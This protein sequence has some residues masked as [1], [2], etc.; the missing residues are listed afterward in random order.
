MI[1]DTPV[2]TPLVS[3]ARS[4][5]S[6]NTILH[7]QFPGGH[8]TLAGSNSPS[9]L[10]SRPIRILEG[11]EI[12][13]WAVSAGAEGSPLVLAI[14]RTTTFWN[15]KKIFASTPTIEGQSNIAALFEASDRRYYHV[16][17]YRCGKFQ[18]LEWGYVQWE[19]GKPETAVYVCRY[20][21]ASWDDSQRQEAIMEGKW[22][23]EA[24]FNGTAGFH[25]WEAYNPWVKLA[26]MAKAFLDAMKQKAM[27]NLEPL[28]AF[29]NTSLGKTW[30][31]QAEAVS[32]DP[33][34][35][36][37]ENYSLDA[38]PW[39]VLYLTCG[40][41]VQDDRLEYEIVGWRAEKRAE[42]EQSWGLENRL[43][44]G[45]P[46]RQ[47]VWDELDEALKR[48]YTTQD[49]RKLRIGATAID[50]GGHHT[51]AVYNFCNKRLG[52]HVYAIKG[53][54]GPR[55]MWPPRAGQSRKF[56][57]SKVWI[58]G[59]DSAK[60]AI[61][62]RLRMTEPGPG[63]CHF[64]VSYD[65][66]FFRQLTA[67]K[68]RTKFVKGF[69]RREWFKAEGV[70]NEA[71]DR[72]VYAFCALYSRRIPWEILVRSAPAEPPPDP[73]SGSTPPATEP[74]TP[75]QRPAAGSRPVR[76]RIGNR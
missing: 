26:E 29:E 15:R 9:G 28:R 50:S 69:P 21:S 41:D 70:R 4:K 3:E 2:L 53:M 33:L 64:P 19:E 35:Q 55:P 62:A 20:C 56:K 52:R 46:A 48:E 24:A 45:D 59:V 30:A 16:P 18:K 63:Y 5:D 25:L 44:Y 27:G 31:E 34:L 58:I 76:F 36:R 10:A 13:R 61:Y 60:D 8:V 22:I 74:P 32:A 6:G 42:T 66:T 68:V 75:P 37:R 49:G 72:R 38:I 67:E 40:V 65:E 1:R 39:P 51:Q 54:Q 43:I 14:K 12:D 17:C 71:L 57:G 11:D 73:P 7:K 23:A 47:E